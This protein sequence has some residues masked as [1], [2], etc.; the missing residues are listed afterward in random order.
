MSLMS[1][2]SFRLAGDALGLKAGIIRI[3]MDAPETNVVYCVQFYPSLPPEIKKGGRPRLEH[4]KREKRIVKPPLVGQLLRVPRLELQELYDAHELVAVSL[5]LPAI[6]YQSLADRKTAETFEHRCNVMSEFLDL[7]KL[8]EELV[9]R[10]NLGRLVQNA[11]VKHK[12]SRGY[13][14]NLWSLLCRF[15][16]TSTSLRPRWYL[17]GARGKPRDLGKDGRKNKAGRKTLAQRINKKIYGHWGEPVQP[18]MNADWRAQ[19][20]SADKRIPIPKPSMRERFKQIVAS[21]FVKSLT[22]DDAGKIVALDLKQGEYPNYQQVKRILTVETSAL[23]KILQKTSKGHFKRSLRGMNSCSW[24]GSPGPGLLYA[25]DSTI[26]DIYLR[27]SVNPEWIIGRPI[28]YIIVDVW[29]TAI[30]GFYVCLTGPSW[31]TAQVS[32]FNATASPALLSDLWGYEMRQSLFPAPTLPARLLCDRGEYLSKRAKATGMKLFLDLQYTPP[33]RPDLKGIV[34]VLH[35]ILKDSQYNFL[36]GAMDARRVEYDLRRSNPAAAT[37]NVRQYTQYLS[38][39]FFIYNLTADRTNRIDAHMA[40]AGV[41]PSPAGLWRWGHAMGIGYLRATAHAELVSQLLPAA[42]ARVTPRG[43]R[44]RGNYY[45]SPLVEKEHWSTF[46]R[47]SGG[48]EIPAQYY[49]GSVSTIWTPNVNGDGLIDLRIADHANASP[50]ITYDDMADAFAFQQLKAADIEHQRVS[51]A[52]LGLKRMEAIR[53]QSIE[54]T[55]IALERTR[56]RAPSITEAR[57]IENEIAAQLDHNEFRGTRKARVE[58]QESHVR[59]MEDIFAA[60][61]REDAND[62]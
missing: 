36:P 44:F 23:E 1:N 15:G 54:Q 2:Q 20:I 35:R 52:V 11:V 5:E 19:I 27:S 50:E 33:F 29:S 49:P 28:V 26:G 9:V 38:E 47:T 16:L 58:V 46:A 6:Y 59:M 45:E 39:R 10:G 41:F 14:Y 18:G 30:V 56:G 7:E 22:Y 48:R 32:L 55:R 57:S 24:Q 25:I 34:E 4:T 40:A 60:K 61:D 37:M 8:K 62:R 43:V 13:V 42:E 3:V 53:Q 31:D 21:H 12:V 17:C 51:D